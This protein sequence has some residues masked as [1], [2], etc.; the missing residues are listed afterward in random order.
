M[1]VTRSARFNSSVNSL[2]YCRFFIKSFLLGIAF[3]L[4]HF[5]RLFNK[6]KIQFC[7]KTINIIRNKFDCV[8]TLCMVLTPIILMTVCFRSYFSFPGA[9][10]WI[11]FTRITSVK[12]QSIPKWNANY[13]ILIEKGYSLLYILPLARSFRDHLSFFL[14]LSVSLSLFLSVSSFAK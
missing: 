12:Y 8:T 11:L 1:V 2:V 7:D 9:F 13:G 6:K 14:S 5:G 3:H 10:I 4:T